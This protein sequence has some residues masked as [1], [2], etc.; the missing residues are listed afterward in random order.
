MSR[1]TTLLRR[2]DGSKVEITVEFWVN[3]RKENYSVVVNFCAP[4]KRKFKPLY[5]SDT[6]QYRNLSLPE[7]LEYAR[8]KQLEVCTEEEIYEAKL[9][10]WES[11]KPEK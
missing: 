11:L 7:R 1:T 6:W 10:C 3:I 2:P 8:K 4:G 5:D 9:K